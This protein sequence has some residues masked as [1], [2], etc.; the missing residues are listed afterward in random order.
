MYTFFV[1]MKATKSWLLLPEQKR[2]AYVTDELVPMLA[3]YPQVTIKFYDVEAF[4]AK[5]SDIAVFETEHLEAYLSLMDDIRNSKITTTPY[6]E[7]VDVFPA[8]VTNYI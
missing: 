5:C 3:K 4:S 1:H 7:T 2:E 6:F 8:K